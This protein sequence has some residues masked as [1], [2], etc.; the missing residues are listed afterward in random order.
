MPPVGAPELPPET[1]HSRPPIQCEECASA[2]QNQGDHSESFL[3]LDQLTV[4]II[5]CR[6]HM[7][8]F[9]S[10]CEVTTTD[11][12][13]L[14]DYLPAGGIRCPSCRLAPYN[15][16]HPV[17]PVQAGAVG[18]LACPEHQVELINRFQAGLNTQEQLT[19]SLDTSP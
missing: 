8:E 3:L 1:S 12:P 11:S 5:G 10:I 19:S 18:I 15:L 16:E 13:E 7:A 9:V 17:I 6:D 4:P 14:V 2:L